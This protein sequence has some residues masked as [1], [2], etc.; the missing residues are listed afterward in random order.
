MGE[1]LGAEALSGSQVSEGGQVTAGRCAAP[2]ARGDSGSHGAGG[3]VVEDH[4]HSLSAALLH[5]R[6][7]VSQQVAQGEA[8]PGQVGGGL[9]GQPD[10][11]APGG[12]CCGLHGR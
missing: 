3:Q 7:A 1:G 9:S 12:G 4:P 5:F 8:K 10:R 2:V 11:G 6:V